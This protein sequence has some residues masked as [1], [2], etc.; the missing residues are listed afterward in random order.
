MQTTSTDSHAWIATS[1]DADLLDM[2]AEYAAGMA[3]AGTPAADWLTETCTAITAALADR[4]I[5]ATISQ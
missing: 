4:N 5:T 1:T 2:L 3:P